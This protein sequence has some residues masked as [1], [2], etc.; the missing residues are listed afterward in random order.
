[1][2]VANGSRSETVRSVPVGSADSA[3]TVASETERT[4]A[5]RSVRADANGCR[6][7][8]ELL[9]DDCPTP[10]LLS[11]ETPTA[12]VGPSPFR[13]CHHPSKSTDLDIPDSG[14]LQTGRPNF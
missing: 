2:S 11:L 14:C 7:H 4:R 3:E 12:A 13:C 9:P 8:A 6:A 5:E 1:M 10:C